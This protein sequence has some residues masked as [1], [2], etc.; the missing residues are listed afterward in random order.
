MKL[1][2]KKKKKKLEQMKMLHPGSPCG[3]PDCGW[4]PDFD[5]F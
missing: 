2:L 3:C 1:W 5:V 4:N